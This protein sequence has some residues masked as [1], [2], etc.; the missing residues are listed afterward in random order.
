[1][2]SDG[3]GLEALMHLRSGSP[4]DDGADLKKAAEP[5][6]RSR[7]AGER[8]GDLAAR[9][10]S[11]VRDRAERLSETVGRGG[12]LADMVRSRPLLSVGVVLASGFLVAAFT[13]SKYEYWPVERARRRLKTLV[14]SG[15]T[16]A[17]VTELR[18]MVDADDGLGSLVESFFQDED[19]NDE[20]YDDYDD[21]DDSDDEFE[22]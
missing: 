9:L 19:E 15:L 16:A 11:S 7:E 3:D 10:R 18:S 8:A 2:H 20:D 22:A 21:Y 6:S 1:M 4:D 12:G 14:V 17:L 13:E 5:R